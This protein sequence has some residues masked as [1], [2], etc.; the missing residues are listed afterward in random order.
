MR[1]GLVLILMYR[2]MGSEEFS[3]GLRMSYKH[4]RLCVKLSVAR[5]QCNRAGGS[6]GGHMKIQP[7]SKL[8]KR[9]VEEL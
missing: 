1:M 4:A 7:R 8:K 6:V 3:F 9:F 2:K 5:R